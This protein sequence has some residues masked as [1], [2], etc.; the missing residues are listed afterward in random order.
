ML[1]G[2]TLSGSIGSDAQEEEGV[3]TVVVESFPEL[4]TLTLMYL[5]NELKDATSEL[6]HRRGINHTVRGS[7]RWSIVGI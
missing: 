2:L 4:K 1:A 6:L 3:I 5:E 7:R